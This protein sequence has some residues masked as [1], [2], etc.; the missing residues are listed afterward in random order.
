MAPVLVPALAPLA[1]SVPKELAINKRGC[2][3][4]KINPRQNIFRGRKKKIQSNPTPV[5]RGAAKIARSK[6]KKASKPKSLPG[7]KVVSEK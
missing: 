6:A 1:T 7:D 3:K 2:L 5:K 4:R